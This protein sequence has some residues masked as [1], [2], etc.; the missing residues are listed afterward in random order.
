MAKSNDNFSD[1]ILT[2]ILFFGGLWLLNKILKQ[3]KNIVGIFGFKYIRD[4]NDYVDRNGNKYF[5]NDLKSFTNDEIGIIIR[6]MIIP[7][8]E[9]NT[10]IKPLFKPL[11]GTI[12]TAELTYNHFRIFLYRLNATDYMLVSV[13]K[14]KTNETPQSEI[15]KAEQRIREFIS[16]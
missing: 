14:K 7:A 11:Q 10:L 4:L 16:R 12:I 6:K 5:Y 15:N 9:T 2:I 3:K 1:I 8:R 13:F